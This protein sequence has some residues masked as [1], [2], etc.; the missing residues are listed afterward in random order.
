M[1]RILSYLP[2]PGL[3]KTE[4][5]K[6]EGEGD[7]ENTAKCGFVGFLFVSFSFFWLKLQF[8]STSRLLC[9]WGGRGISMIY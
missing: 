5:I 9:A 1:G 4:P 8:W 6:Q 2:L 3:Y 7:D